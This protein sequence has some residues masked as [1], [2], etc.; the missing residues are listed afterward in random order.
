MAPTL[1][2]EVGRPEAALDEIALTLIKVSQ[3]VIDFGEVVELD[4]NPLL[5]DEFG[6]M[7]LDAR[8]RVRPARE[9]PARRLAIRPYP[10]ELE[11]TF[12]LRDGR[13]VLL[14]PVK[15]EDEPALQD[16]FAPMSPQDIRMRFFAP[17]RMLSHALAAR[18]TQIDY[19]RD[20][21]LV[22]AEPGIPGQADVY[23]VASIAADPD[24]EQ[25]SMQSWFAAT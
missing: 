24:G 6:V 12:S 10:K 1:C 18:M 23:A 3:L 22:L 17:K 11:E 15:P 2:R 21:A 13:S 4:I 5:A 19:D 16:F 7:A 8:V 20:I 9:I 14:R 25:R